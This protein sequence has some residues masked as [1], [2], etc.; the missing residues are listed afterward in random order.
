MSTK[1]LKSLAEIQTGYTFRSNLSEYSS[2]NT[3][4]LQ[5][6]DLPDS[7]TVTNK[8]T[9]V[10]IA[11]VSHST[12]FVKTNDLVF[13]ARGKFQASVVQTDEPLLVASSLY[14]LRPDTSQVLPDYLAIVLNS[15]EN[16][17]KFHAMSKTTTVATVSK[18]DLESIEVVVP[19]LKTQKTL[20]ALYHNITAQKQLVEKKFKNVEAVFEA[21][22][23]K[24]A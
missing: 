4:V 10:S 19:S 16:Q 22:L 3:A 1:T 6:K 11:S 23:A 14:I 5:S 20:V 21:A 15:S 8:D 9:T 12:A 2:G 18:K 7:L 24:Q 17:Q 13:A